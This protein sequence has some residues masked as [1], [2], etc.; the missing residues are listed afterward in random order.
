MAGY[1]ARAAQNELSVD[2][3]LVVFFFNDFNAQT[4]KCLESIV[5]R[6]FF[7]DNSYELW[8]T[9]AD[10]RA[11]P[12]SADLVLSTQSIRAGESKRYRAFKRV[13][14]CE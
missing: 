4:P 13:A 5:F 10:W 2:N 1:R 8:I 6:D 11:S 7:L 3:F 12:T 9:S 14:F